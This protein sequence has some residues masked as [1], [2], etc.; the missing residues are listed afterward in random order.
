MDGTETIIAWYLSSVEDISGNYISYTYETRSGNLLLKEVGYGG[1]ST[2]NQEHIYNVKFNYI[3]NRV[4]PFTSYINGA[5]F[6]TDYLLDNI[7]I[8]YIPENKEM[9]KYSLEYD[10]SAIIYSRL[11][12]IIV[13]D[14]VN[15]VEMNPTS[16]EWGETTENFTYAET[17]IRKKA[18][19]LE[20][21]YTLGDFNGDGKTDILVA[22]LDTEAKKYVS[23]SIF[24]LNAL[25]TSYNE[26]E[27]GSLDEPYQPAFAYFLAGDF[28]GDGID[29]LLKVTSHGPDMHG[30]YL[31]ISDGNNN[32]SYGGA[33][34]MQ[35]NGGHYIKITDMNGN[36]INEVL[37]VKIN[38]DYGISFYCYE[39]S[40]SNNSFMS[41]FTNP[42]SSSGYTIQCGDEIGRASCRER[43]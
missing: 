15:A 18:A 28:N 32:F 21:K 34:P 22:Y 17:N 25:G 37:L 19:N 40:L 20:N 43:V 2:A 5:A 7:T 26:V 29:D 6:T 24:Y 4:D 12:K 9:F 38:G 27:M 10:E 42:P 35:F 39:K 16:I 36:G 13:T 23:W 14:K 1:N 33:L 11:V 31:Y 3:Y 30:C 8:N 41:L